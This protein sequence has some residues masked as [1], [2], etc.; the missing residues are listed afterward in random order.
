MMYNMMDINDIS[1]STGTPV[2]ILISIKKNK[3]R[4]FHCG[5]TQLSDKERKKGWCA[6]KL[7][8]EGFLLE[9]IFRSLFPINFFS[10]ETFTFYLILFFN[11]SIMINCR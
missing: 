2:E 10:G 9:I 4:V 7:D 6:T 11:K 8:S 1:K 5:K 3:D